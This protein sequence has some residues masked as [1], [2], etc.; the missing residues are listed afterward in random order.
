MVSV[1]HIPTAWNYADIMTKPL[2]KIQF[3]RI[4]D[5][6]VAPEANGLRDS[7][8]ESG[9]EEEVANFTFISGEEC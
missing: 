7:G 1:K 3:A 9:L 4:L 6:C 2:G 5:L 8:E